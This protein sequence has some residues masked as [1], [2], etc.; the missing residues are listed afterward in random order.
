MGAHSTTRA[1]SLSSSLFIIRYFIFFFYCCFFFFCFVLRSFA[2]IKG[3][4]PTCF[5]TSFYKE[6]LYHDEL[7]F[8]A[9]KIRPGTS[10]SYPPP[11]R[12]A[13]GG[14][15]DSPAVP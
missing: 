12:R 9:R 2:P 8:N 10:L 14:C 1:S 5:T 3:V 6:K 15:H 7:L 11:S 4:S 13:A